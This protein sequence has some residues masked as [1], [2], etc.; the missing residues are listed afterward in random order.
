MVN[1]P[2]PPSPKSPDSL[3]SLLSLCSSSPAT[4]F[5]HAETSVLSGIVSGIYQEM[6]QCRD[7]ETDLLSSLEYREL[8]LDSK[9]FNLRPYQSQEDARIV[10]ALEQDL[11]DIERQRIQTRQ[12][13]AQEVHNLQKLFWHYL[14]EL[15]R[16]SSVLR[17]LQ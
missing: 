2:N 8:Y 15:H 5:L 3:D 14:L 9:K 17:F 4:E 11:I 6:H 7:L 16:K 12:S 13:A 10:S 1:H